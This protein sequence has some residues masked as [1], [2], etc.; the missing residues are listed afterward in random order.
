MVTLQWDKATVF[1]TKTTSGTVPVVVVLWLSNQPAEP[2][3]WLREEEK[4]KATRR[5][6]WL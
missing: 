5:T 6:G 1:F 4:K 2:S 3:P